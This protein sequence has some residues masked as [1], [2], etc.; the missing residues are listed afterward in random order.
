MNRTWLPPSIPLGVVLLL[1][2]PGCA[3]FQVGLEAYQR[4]D[5]ETALKE[6]RPLANH[7]DARAQTKLGYMYLEGLGVP[8]DYQEALRWYR[9]SSEQGD[10]RGQTS[11]GAMYQFGLGVPQEY[12]EAVRWYR[13]AAEQGDA[14]GQFN[15]SSMYGEGQGVPRNFVQAYMWMTLATA[16]G[17]EISVTGLKILEKEMTPAQLAEAQRLAREWKPKGKNGVSGRVQRADAEE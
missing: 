13:R 12:Q 11:L 7:G 15:L 16:R 5:Y 3:D 9:L 17:N 14:S 2:A 8:Q 1:V 6:W 10:A 4:D